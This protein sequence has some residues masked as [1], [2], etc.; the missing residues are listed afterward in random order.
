MERGNVLAAAL[1]DDDRVG[2]LGNQA[3]DVLDRRSVGVHLWGG[4]RLGHPGRGHPFGTHDL[5]GYV[6]VGRSFRNPLGE[7]SSPAD[8]LVKGMGTGDVAAPLDEGVHQAVGPADY[9]QVP[10]PLGAGVEFGVFP[11][12]D[13]LAGADDHGNFGQVCPVDSQRPLKQAHAGVQQYGLKAACHPGV[14]HGHSDRQGL[15]PAVNVPRAVYLVG[16]L[17]G[18]GFPHGGPLG[19]RR[20]YDVVHSQ[21]AERFQDGLATVNFLGRHRSL[22]KK[23][24]TACLRQVLLDAHY[25][26]F[27]I[28]L[29]LC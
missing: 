2:G 13:G 28:G 4:G 23:C 1:C 19:T 18:Q 26:T 25:T 20:G 27:G 15:V 9:T 29:G 8:R 7:F 21:I 16:L 6:Q 11:V 14:A 22:L 12:G 17:P 3:G 5:D 24:W 10:V